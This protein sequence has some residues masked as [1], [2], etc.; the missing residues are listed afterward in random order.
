MCRASNTMR[1]G[2]EIS[3]KGANPSTTGW[4]DYEYVTSGTYTAA[5]DAV[6]SNY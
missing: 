4:H 3:S 6:S 5:N 2:M 1:C